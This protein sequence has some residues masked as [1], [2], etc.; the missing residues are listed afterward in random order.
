[1]QDVTFERMMM[2]DQSVLVLL[3]RLIDKTRCSSHRVRDS[4]FAV[5]DSILALMT[6][7][8]ARA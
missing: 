3:A 5:I 6:S 4:V 7:L 1:M 2:G 8:E